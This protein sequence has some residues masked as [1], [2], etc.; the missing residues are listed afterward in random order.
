MIKRDLRFL[1]MLPVLFVMLALGACVR[2]DDSP[3]WDKLN[4]H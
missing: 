3:I 1:L 4:E 2:F